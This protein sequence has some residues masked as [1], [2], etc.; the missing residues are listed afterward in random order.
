MADAKISELAAAAAVTADDLLALVDDPGGT[1]ASKKATITQL[2]T[3]LRSLSEELTN[4]TIN[5][6][7]NTITNVSLTTGVTGT[8]PIGNGGTGASSLAA[9]LI[10][11]NGTVLSSI[12]TSAAVRS[13]ISDETG[14]GAMVFADTPTLVTPNI[15]AAT[16]TSLNL[17]GALTLGTDLSVPNGGTGAS[18]FTSGE[19]L[20]GAGASALTT[21]S[22]VKAGTNY[23]SINNASPG[24]DGIFLANAYGVYFRNGAGSANVRGVYLGGSNE[25][26][27]GD[28][29]NTT[30]AQGSVVQ[31][32]TDDFRVV[33]AAGTITRFDVTANGQFRVIDAGGDHRLTFAVPD[34]AAARTLNVPLLTA[35]DTI[36][37][38]AFTQ[39]LTNKT[40]TSPSINSAT[41]TNG[42]L[43]GVT[44]TT[45]ITLS[46]AGLTATG[47]STKGTSYDKCPVDVSTTDATVTTLDSFTIGSNTA[48]A[49]TWMVTAI[50]SDRSEAAAYSVSAVF[51][52][53]G[54]TVAQVGTTTTTVLGESDSAWTA[55]IDNSTTTI[56]LRVTGKAATT[57]QWTAIMTRLDV[58]P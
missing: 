9:G 28:T 45:S 19:V 47:S 13:L 5:G 44:H 20:V 10:Q 39:T 24:A 32:V 49:V 51:R 15:G 21:A 27:L 50:K 8:L 56:R 46:G 6:S 48:A 34:L 58:A 26:I 43:V 16:G 22:N 53:N 40:L 7:S 2:A 4:K 35:N 54:G 3:F 11:S 52:N 57:I 14:T 55:T 33:N 38:A 17:S 30:Q 31:S 18:T 1:P 23:V 29:A 42:S 37:T 41:I 25:L 12:T 36:V